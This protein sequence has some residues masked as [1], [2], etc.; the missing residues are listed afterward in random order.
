MNALKFNPTTVSVDLGGT[1]ISLET[2]SIAKQAH[3]AV[4]VRQGDTM[5]L[6]A[7]CYGTPR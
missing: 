1:P 7:V 2:G 6:V 5:V 3:G 4:V